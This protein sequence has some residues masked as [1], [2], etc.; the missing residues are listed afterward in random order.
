MKYPREV[1]IYCKYCRK[2]TLQKVKQEKKRARSSAHPESSSQRR[3]K[4]KTKGYGGFPRPQPSGEG[5]PSKKVDL[6]FKCSVCNKVNVK[7]KGFRA[8]KFELV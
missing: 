1:R 8:K 3:F 6:R 7:G 4:R 5:K 2:H